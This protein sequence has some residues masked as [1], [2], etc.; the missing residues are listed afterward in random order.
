MVT[1]T[2]VLKVLYR[3]VYGFYGPR[4]PANWT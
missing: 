4:F 2:E 3:Q 1:V